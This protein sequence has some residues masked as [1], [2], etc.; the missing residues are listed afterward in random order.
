MNLKV[1]LEGY[2]ISFLNSRVLTDFLGGHL[3]MITSVF[4]TTLKMYHAFAQSIKSLECCK[5]PNE[6]GFILHLAA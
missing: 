6:G 2:G 4:A 5:S 3:M 1:L